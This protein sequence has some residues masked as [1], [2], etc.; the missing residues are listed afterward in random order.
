MLSSAQIAELEAFA[1]RIRMETVKAMGTLG[2]GHVGGALSIVDTLAVLYGS[3][4]KVNPQNPNWE[5][6]DWLI[7]SK[8]H[9]GPAVYAALAL[10]GYFPLEEL[11]TLN[12]PRTCLPSH[13]DRNKTVGIDMTTG[14]L[15]QG[16]SLAVG[17]ALGHKLD[18][19]SNYTYLI[20]GDGEIQEGQVWEAALYAAQKK[21]DNLVAF[22]DANQKQLD[23]WV[24]EINDLGSIKIKFQSFGWHVQ[25]VDGANVGEIAEAVELA[26][27][28]KGQPSVIV[29]HTVKGKGWSL[30]ENT[31]ANHHMTIS[32][33]QM[34]EALAVFEEQLAKVVQG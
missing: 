13:C 20:M 1:L 25:E 6:R 26:K 11:S 10:K 9:A 2:F 3:V 5:E 33:E 14:S 34:A 16:S 8:G 18:K 22:I 19:K 23:G 4:M 12:R 17:A 32:P 28:A 27:A 21:L 30:A 15:G 24:K 29:L 31:I 7:C